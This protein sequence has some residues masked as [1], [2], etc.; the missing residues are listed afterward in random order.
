MIKVLREAGATASGVQSSSATL[1][2]PCSYMNFRSPRHHALSI[3]LCAYAPSR[4]TGLLRKKAR[5][6]QAN[7]S[8]ETLR[9]PAVR[10]CYFAETKRKPPDAATDWSKPEIT[11]NSV[12]MHGET[13]SKKLKV[14]AVSCHY[15]QALYKHLPP[16]PLTHRPQSVKSHA[17]ILRS[18]LQISSLHHDLAG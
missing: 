4:L 7:Q 14:S 5:P 8:L 17:Q 3:F 6:V 2:R 9:K 15:H 10:A 13:A 11:C 16:H 1:T 12:G 18:I